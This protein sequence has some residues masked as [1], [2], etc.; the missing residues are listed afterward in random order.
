[1]S[2]KT[3]TEYV[4]VYRIIL[5]KAP[6]VLTNTEEEPGSPDENRDVFHPLSLGLRV[7]PIKTWVWVVRKNWGTFIQAGAFIQH[8]TM[9]SI[10]GWPNNSNLLIQNGVYEN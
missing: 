1:M 5:N 9:I 4:W 10:D 3:A 2:A 7:H 8:Y 6:C